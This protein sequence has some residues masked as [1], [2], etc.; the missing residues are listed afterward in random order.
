V[1]EGGSL[2][3]DISRQAT[4]YQ[5]Q[6]LDMNSLDMK[7]AVYFHQDVYSIQKHYNFLTE[8]SKCSEMISQDLINRMTDQWL[9]RTSCR[10]HIE[11]HLD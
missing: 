3:Q 7:P 1:L 4:I 10:R 5:D 11:H 8:D 9:R 6:Q 2:I